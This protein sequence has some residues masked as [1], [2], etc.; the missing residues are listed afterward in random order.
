MRLP[1]GSAGV[2]D[3]TAIIKGLSSKDKDAIKEKF[4]AFNASFEELSQAESEHGARGQKLLAREVQAM[5]EPLYGR[6]WDR[7]HEIDRGREICEV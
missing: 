3:S 1:S 2:I 4:K 6:F 5:I 7:Y